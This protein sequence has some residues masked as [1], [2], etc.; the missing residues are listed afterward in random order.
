MTTEKVDFESMIQAAWEEAKRN[1]S[2]LIK[3]I[4]RDGLLFAW[5]S[6]RSYIGCDLYQPIRVENM[7][8]FWTLI[9]HACG[10]DFD[11]EEKAIVLSSFFEAMIKM[12]LYSAEKAEEIVKNCVAKKRFPISWVVDTARTEKMLMAIRALYLWA[13]IRHKGSDDGLADMQ[14]AGP[15]W[16]LCKDYGI[17][18]GQKSK[19]ALFAQFVSDAGA[20]NQAA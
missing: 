18:L 16:S 2:L 14:A 7:S 13:L 17:Q 3:I 4:N 1:K 11:E 6:D 10:I 12:G 15:F 9:H 20:G 8:F 19:E 5:A